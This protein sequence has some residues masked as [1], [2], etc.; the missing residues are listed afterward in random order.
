MTPDERALARELRARGAPIFALMAKFNATRG[1]I[2]WAL[3]PRQRPGRAHGGNKARDEA[4]IICTLRE[5]RTGL[6]R[7]MHIPGKRYDAT[8]L[9]V[10]MIDAMPGEWRLLSYSTPET[11]ATD[12]DGMRMSGQMPELNALARHGRLDLLDPSV[13]RER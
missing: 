5:Q 8:K 4:G 9:L 1:A 11:I 13:R 10:R 12:L 2:E 3:N 7:V 6:R